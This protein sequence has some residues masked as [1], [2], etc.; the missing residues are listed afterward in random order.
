MAGR[1]EHPVVSIAKGRHDAPARV[2]LIG[3]LRQSLERLRA[4][5]GARNHLLTGGVVVMTA[6]GE[7]T[8]SITL[9]QVKLIAVSLGLATCTV[10]CDDPAPLR[11]SFLPQ[12]REAS[13]RPGMVVLA[14]QIHRL[15]PVKLRTLQ[16]GLRRAQTQGYPVM[17]VATAR[18]EILSQITDAGMFVISCLD[19]GDENPP[20]PHEFGI[21]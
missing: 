3:D 13:R 18:A 4:G 8:A 5:T 21:T 11:Y 6:D 10:D 1:Y 17:M 20:G 9:R 12:L 19:M 7:S 16:N 2:P 15:E 14:P